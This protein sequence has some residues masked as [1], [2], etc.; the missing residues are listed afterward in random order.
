MGK[1]I[2]AV[3]EGLRTTYPSASNP[4]WRSLPL[5]K[6]RRLLV[7]TFLLASVAGFAANLTMLDHRAILYGFFWP[8]LIAC[9]AT[10]IFVI[11]LRSVRW[12]ILAFP[13]AVGSFL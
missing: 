8:V 9:V 11:R 12:I 13:V 2:S 3:I 4:Y 6:M 1:R 7:G 5:R 10:S